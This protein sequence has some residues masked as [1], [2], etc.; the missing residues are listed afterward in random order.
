MAEIPIIHEDPAYLVVEKPSGLLVH[1]SPH[2]SGETLSER[3][4]AMYPELKTVGDDP[5]LRPGIVHRLDRD[6]SGLLVVARTQE[7]FEHLKTQ[8]QNRTIEKHYTA[9]VHG[10][11]GKDAGAINAPLGR[12][13][14]TGR[15][16]AV[17][18]EGREALT[19]FTVVKRLQHYTLLDVQIHTGRTHQIRVHM[20]SIGHAIVG[21]AQYR[22]RK[23]KDN[24]PR[25][26]LHA[27]SLAFTDLH[28]KRVRYESPLPEELAA[29]L[30]KQGGS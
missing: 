2:E 21:D 11:V 20:A 17:R 8:F 10:I 13:N 6:V 28:G 25:P 4:A 16:A 30:K 12:S 3:L 27:T 1:P 14:R 5:T 24:F 22:P 19:T 9:L 29:F 23:M 15:I 26:F 7:M 18:N